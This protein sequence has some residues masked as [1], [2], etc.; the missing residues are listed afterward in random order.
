MQKI[1]LITIPYAGGSPAIYRP[2]QAV[3]PST[4]ELKTITLPGRDVR[5]NEKLITDLNAAVVDLYQQIKNFINTPY[6]FFGHS[7]G[8]ILAYEL[9]QYLS[10]N[11]LPLPQHLFVSGCRAPQIFKRR[12][13]LHQLPD[14]ELAANIQ[15]EY[16]SIPPVIFHNHEMLSIFLQTMR[17]DLTI[18]EKYS[19]SAHPPLSMPITAIGGSDDNYSNG[20]NALAWKVQTTDVFKYHTVLGDH[21]GMLNDPKKIMNIIL[22]DLAAMKE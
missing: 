10:K 7:L 14:K 16:K 5:F 22:G 19:Y 15:L 21:I 9:T 6:V 8:A 12:K 4:L 3:C 20:E 2:W 17:A 1:R 11:T 13:P 18:A